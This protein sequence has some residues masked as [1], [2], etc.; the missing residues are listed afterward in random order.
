MV[1]FD[2]LKEDLGL[3]VYPN[4]IQDRVDLITG[5]E[6]NITK[7]RIVGYDTNNLLFNT[8]TR[9][10][11]RKE[12]VKA[13]KVLNMINVE[14][15]IDKRSFEDEIMMSIFIASHPVFADKYEF[16]IYNDV[17][18]GYDSSHTTEG[19]TACMTDMHLEVDG[20]FDIYIDNG[21]KLAALVSKYEEEIVARALLWD[22]SKVEHKILNIDGTITTKPVLLD[23]VYGNYA[24]AY[25][26][27][28]HCLDMGYYVRR[29]IP[30]SQG[31]ETTVF[32][33]RTGTSLSRIELFISIDYDVPC[34]YI[35]T[36]RGWRPNIGI[37]N[38]VEYYD[39][40]L[41]TTSGYSPAWEDIHEGDDYEQSDDE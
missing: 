18:Y 29:S 30:N 2:K 25:L 21:V 8:E 9:L 37:A 7:T 23:R 41:N 11:R 27:Q 10:H 39:Y 16:R 15:R 13:G 31:E 14:N 22:L 3:F 12:S 19:I 6:D 36:F 28:R 26:L 17:T 24:E 4:Y 35:D 32:V 20:V 33:D 1:I 38:G 34:P 40:Y 5:L